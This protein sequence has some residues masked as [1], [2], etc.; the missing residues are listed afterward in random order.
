MKLFEYC[1][2][3][4][5]SDIFFDG[6][7]KFS[8]KACSFT[9]FQNVAAAVA[10]ILEYDQKIIL[11]K[12]SKE[13]GKGKLD[14]PGGFVDPEEAAEDA[15]RRE[16][17]EELR[18]DVGTLKYVGSYPNIYEYKGVLYRTCDLF[19]YSKIDALPTS[20][21]KTE[22]EEFVLMNPSEVPDDK[23]AFKSTGIGLDLFGQNL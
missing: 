7:K 18:I 5:S 12:R 20:F 13:P 11:I 6:I 23:I 15:V 4:G 17:N 3:C 14:F 10:A 21:D 2:C 19:F 1:P 8:C 22:I 9:F 16:I